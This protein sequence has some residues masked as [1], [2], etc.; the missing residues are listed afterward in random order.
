M[1]TQA[2]LGLGRVFD[3]VYTP[4]AHPIKM[5]NANAISLVT[6]A[7]ST[8]TT[9][10]TV[11]AQKTFSGSAVNWTTANGFGQPSAW[12][13]NTVNDGTAAWVK[14]AASWASNVLTIAATSGYVSV[15][16]FY[17][18]QFA[19]GYEYFLLQTATNNVPFAIL[20]DLA[21]QRTP[22]NLEVL[23]S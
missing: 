3:V 12:Y 6:K 10:L 20:H 8:A 16:T 15:V 5:R 14:E 11:Q 21:V 18:T 17:A 1:V 13:Q 22:A 19:D 4:A 23:G 9:S 2:G 7:S